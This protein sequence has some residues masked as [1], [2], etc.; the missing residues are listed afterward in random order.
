MRIDQLTV[1]NFRRFEKNT[2]EF[3]P[4]FTL[5]VGGQRR[6]QDGASGG[7]SGGCGDVFD[8]DRQFARTRTLYQ[9]G[10]HTAGDSARR[11]VLHL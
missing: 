3:H 4:R 7:A 9:A 6:R 1:L 8:G 10:L 11:R 5:L 2:F